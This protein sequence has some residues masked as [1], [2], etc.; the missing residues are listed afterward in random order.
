MELSSLDEPDGEPRARGTRLRDSASVSPQGR[1]RL[2]PGENGGS[3]D[4]QGGEEREGHLGS[5]MAKVTRPCVSETKG[6]RP[7]GPRPESVGGAR[8][9]IRE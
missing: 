1:E 3:L 4:N 2:S 9:E 5:E 6:N 7:A 8:K